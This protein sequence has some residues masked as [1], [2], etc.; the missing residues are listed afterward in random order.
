MYK[1]LVLFATI[2]ACCSG[3]AR[4][5]FAW[6]TCWCEIDT[7]W[8]NGTRNASQMD[9]TTAVNWSYNGCLDPWWA[10]EQCNANISDCSSRCNKACAGYVNSQSFASTLCAKGIPNG[11]ALK[12]N[13]HVGTLTAWQVNQ[14]IG[15]LTN[16]PA[17]SNTVCTCPKPW[18]NGE[19]VVGGTT[20]VDKNC[21]I[22]VCGPI[23]PGPGTSLPP[24][25]TSTNSS[26]SW[27]TWGN[28]LIETAPVANC[29]TTPLSIAQ[30]G[31]SLGPGTW[32]D[33]F[34][35]DNEGGMGDYELLQGLVDSKKVCA[36][37]LSI[38]CQTASGVDWAKSNLVYHCDL[39][40]GG[41]CVQAEQVTGKSCVDFKV[42]FLCG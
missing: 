41:Y 40:K 24:N 7:V 28:E 15:T 20:G 2:L 6:V 4:E 27:W 32:T 29:V 21:K 11:T 31:F 34:N 10:G 30:C 22:K 25:G 42:R 9:L 16:I 1:K 3:S 5:A 8:S 26:P 12:C 38:E 33:W 14:D 13:S 36:H 37:P 17:V 23:T 18:L 35:G 39:S 19:N